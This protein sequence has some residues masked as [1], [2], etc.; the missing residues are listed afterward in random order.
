[1][2]TLARLEHQTLQPLCASR[3]DYRTGENRSRSAVRMNVTPIQLP[4]RVDHAIPRNTSRRNIVA[5]TQK[6]W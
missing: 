2:N 1:M 4:R 6:N 5:R 3:E